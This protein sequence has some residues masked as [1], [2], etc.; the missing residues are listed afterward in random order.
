MKRRTV[1]FTWEDEDAQEAFREWCPFPDAQASAHDVD[2][3]EAFLHLTPPLDVLDVG[4]GTGTLLNHYRE[5]GC[6]TFGID[7]SQAMLRVAREKL[8]DLTLGDASRM[9]FPDGSFDLVTAM[10][11]F[12]EM[13][14]LL[15]SP[16]MSDAKRVLKRGG[17]LLIIDYHPGPIHSSEGWLHKATITLI[18]SLAGR[19]HSRNYRSFMANGGLMPLLAENGLLVD[20]KR[21]VG[22]GTIGLYLLRLD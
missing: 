8:N 18:E 10:L 9:P 11:T 1:N 3:I 6:R 15:R 19:E 14:A 22:D 12:H 13:P 16:V 5:A 7:L 21:V 4:C 2:R 20:A 17:R